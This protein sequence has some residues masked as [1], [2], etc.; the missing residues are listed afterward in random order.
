MTGGTVCHGFNLIFPNQ[1][2][3]LL[4]GLFPRPVD[5]ENLGPGANEL[6]R[7]SMTFQAPLHVEGVRFPDKGHLVDLP[8]TGRT[9][10]S[11]AHMDTVVEVDEI[12]KIV[13]PIP[14]QR[15]TARI[16]LSYRFQ[17]R[18]IGPDLRVACHAGL[19]R[20]HAREATFLD[21][22][23]AVATI[24]SQALDVMLVAEWNGLLCG[25]ADI[26][27]VGRTVY[28]GRHPEKGRHYKECAEN[29]E[30]RKCVRTSMKNLSHSA[31]Y[32]NTFRPGTLKHRGSEIV[33]S[34]A[35][36]RFPFRLQG[37][38]AGLRPAG[39]LPDAKRQSKSD[40]ILSP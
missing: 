22:G 35:I 23:M 20:R 15:H 40:I 17:H 24:Q 7:R 37:L 39:G 26:G 14:V 1:L 30:T 10:D 38:R 25:D 27:H 16:A 3:P 4:V 8:V 12:R 36:L 13:D 29:A 18:A 5:T 19:C 2:S 11:P 31:A 6:F 34:K 33:L 9:S 32:P 28:R 21:A